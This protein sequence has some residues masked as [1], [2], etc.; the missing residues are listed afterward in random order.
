MD[1]ATYCSTYKQKNVRCK[2]R[3]SPNGQTFNSF[4]VEAWHSIT[5]EKLLTF[6]FS[7]DENLLQ[8][9]ELTKIIQH[10][11]SQ[12][13]YFTSAK[14]TEPKGL[15]RRNVW[16]VVDCKTITPNSDMLTGQ[17]VLAIKDEGVQNENLTV[18]HII[19]VRFDETN[20]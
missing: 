13:N 9:I 8:Q 6:K 1:R 4:Q 19:Q 12:V 18:R 15:V 14:E 17:F 7:A 2:I 10:Y 3:N 16:K 20:K 11:N 5:R